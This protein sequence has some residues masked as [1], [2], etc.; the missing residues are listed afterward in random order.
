MLDGI[1]ITNVT[2]FPLP[3]GTEP[4]PAYPTGYI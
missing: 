2:E 4:V 3:D 1:L